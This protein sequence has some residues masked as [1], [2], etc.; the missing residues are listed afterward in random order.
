MTWR[1]SILLGRTPHPG[2]LL[3]SSCLRVEV[4]LIVAFQLG[5]SAPCGNPIGHLTWRAIGKSGSGFSYRAG[6]QD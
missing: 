4:S 2:G 6:Y 5:Q 1:I 3:S